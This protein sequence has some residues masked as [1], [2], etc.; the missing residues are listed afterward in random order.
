MNPYESPKT[1]DKDT[2]V[3]ATWIDL[4]IELY[5]AASD[6]YGE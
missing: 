6:C 1:E 2:V 3:M 4:P 5:W